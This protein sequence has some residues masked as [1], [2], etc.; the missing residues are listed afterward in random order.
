MVN[1]G[2]QK[3]LSFWKCGKK[4]WIL[5]ENCNASTHSHILITVTRSSLKSLKNAIDMVVPM[6]MDHAYDTKAIALNNTARVFMTAN[7]KSYLWLLIAVISHI[8][9]LQIWIWRSWKAY[10]NIGCCS[11]CKSSH[12]L[13]EESW[14]ELIDH[15]HWIGDLC[16]TS[17]LN[18]ERNLSLMGSKLNVLP[19][20]FSV[21]LHWI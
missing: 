4:L 20:G 14:I 8:A 18:L 11:G 1:K 3:T 5:P 9:K 16:L 13:F 2:N 15:N 19:V 12:N 21:L 7:F 17:L 6:L 10:P